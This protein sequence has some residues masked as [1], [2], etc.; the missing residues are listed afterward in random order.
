MKNA[1]L[2]SS[3]FIGVC[4]LV[5]TYV[6]AIP[7][8]SPALSLR[9][10]TRACVPAI[11]AATTIDCSNTTSVS[12]AILTQDSRYLLFCSDASYL[13][14]GTTAP[15]AAAGDMIVPS[16][17]WLDFATDAETRYVACK[18]VNS[19]AACYYIHCK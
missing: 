1:V 8:T 18:N 19:D 6:G 15:T 11:G 9:E 10:F 4:L 7:N 12:S 16:G 13:R 14:W 5:A 2:I 17:T 3:A